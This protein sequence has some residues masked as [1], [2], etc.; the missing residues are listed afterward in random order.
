MKNFSLIIYLL[1]I[2]V[3]PAVSSAQIAVNGTGGKLGDYMNTIMGFFDDIILPFI[4]SIA[5]LF[6]VWGVFLY[7]IRG[8]HSDEAQE[9]G[10]SYII[11]AIIGFVI[12]LSFWGLVNIITNGVG[13]EGKKGVSPKA[14]PGAP[15]PTT[16]E[17]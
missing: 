7:F 12:I 14:T 10:R 13:L 5:F 15:A 1:T 2:L 4:L 3:L 6:F 11:S 17:V 9:Q 8:G 16:I